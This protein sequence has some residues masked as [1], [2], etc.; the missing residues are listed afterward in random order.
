MPNM[1]LILFVFVAALALAASAA[2]AGPVRATMSTSSTQP[3]AGMPWRYT[4]VVKDQAGNPLAAKVRL[5]LLRG[6]R[7]VGCWKTT[8]M[9]RCS[10]A[11]AGTWIAFKGKRTAVIAWPARS[12]GV[13]LVF[14]ATV[15]AGTQAL[16]LRAPVTVRLP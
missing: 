13:R 7:V 4:I 1:R 14:R 5:Q 8:A 11:R 10:G 3:L 15:V 12:A 9:V 6:A 16:T 2:A